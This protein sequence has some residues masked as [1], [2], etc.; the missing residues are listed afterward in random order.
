MT[1]DLKKKRK[2]RKPPTGY[3]LGDAMPESLRAIGLQYRESL[4]RGK[5]RKSIN[6]GD[7][8]YGKRAEN[9]RSK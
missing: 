2:Y 3:K 8:R 4:N 6:K 9:T 1:N 7:Q 5:I